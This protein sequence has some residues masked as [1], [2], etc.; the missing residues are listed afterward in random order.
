[1]ANCVLI[2]YISRN[3]AHL[4]VKIAHLNYSVRIFVK[5]YINIV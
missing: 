4:L 1:M 2:E 5:N 3:N